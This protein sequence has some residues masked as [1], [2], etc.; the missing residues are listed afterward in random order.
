[1]V[2]IVKTMKCRLLDWLM[3]WM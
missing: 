3:G 1:M 2:C